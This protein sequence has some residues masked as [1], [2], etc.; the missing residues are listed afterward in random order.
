[1]STARGFANHSLYM[2]RLVLSAWS[3]QVGT[4]NLPPGTAAAAFAPAVRLHLL[5][6][7]G[8]FLLALLRVSPL[9]P[10][11]PHSVSE[12]PSPGPG[13]AL[14]GELAEYSV[15]ER[16]GWLARLQAPLAPGIPQTAAP[17]LLARAGGYPDRSD[18]MEWCQQFEQLFDR[19]SDS[20]DEY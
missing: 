6:A 2:A 16:E 20:I 9:P 4:T 5:D 12:L 18:Y 15:L 19:M 8:W 10:R 14:P 17:D 7:Y 1:M 3:T 13:I 11:P